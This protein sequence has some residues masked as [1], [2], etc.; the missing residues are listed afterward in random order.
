MMFLIQR[1]LNLEFNKDVRVIAGVFIFPLNELTKGCGKMS[2]SIGEVATMYQVT[3]PALRFYEQEGL[4][5]PIARDAAGRRQ[6]SAHDLKIVAQIVNLKRTK[7]PLTD[8]AT[9]LTLY[10]EGDATWEDRREVYDKQ[11]DR[12]AQQAAQLAETQVYV[13]FKQWYADQLVT[14]GSVQ[15]A[16]F[17]ARSAAEFAT[18]LKNTGQTDQLTTFNRLLAKYPDGLCAVSLKEL[19]V[20]QTN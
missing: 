12:L 14:L 20:A 1:Q 19:L 6:Y 3:V 5:P 17:Q 9:Y 15:E 13:S 11:A 18:H 7:M 10:Q 8:I 2:Y 16:D 4:L